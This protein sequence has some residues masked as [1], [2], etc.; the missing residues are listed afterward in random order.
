MST[1]IVST[2]PLESAAVA[3]R[4]GVLGLLC[5][6]VA[7]IHFS[8]YQADL[9]GLSWLGIVLFHA[10]LGMICAGMAEMRRRNAFGVVLFCSLGLF[11]LS[12]LA[13]IVLPGSGYGNV[14]T[15]PTLVA[16]LGIWGL[17]CAILASG[18]GSRNRFVQVVIE[19]LALF[20]FLMAA[21]SAGSFASVSV[22]ATAVGVVCGTLA[23]VAAAVEG[24]RYRRSH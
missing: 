8:L 14:P 6:G 17:F 4:A 7:T 11:W 23:A 19:F 13:L 16:Y 20:L 9:I 1:T 5:L 15:Q 22:F 2:R 21:A 18:A 3:A 10:A 12:L 24:K